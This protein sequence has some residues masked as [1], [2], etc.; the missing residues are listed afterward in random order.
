M[1]AGLP[2][3]EQANS[4]EDASEAPRSKFAATARRLLGVVGI[5][6]PFIAMLTLGL[7]S[8]TLNVIG[9]LLLGRATDLVLAGVIGRQNPGMDKSDVIDRLRQ[10]GQSA[11]AGM[12]QSTGF[13]PGRSS[14][15]AAVSTI[16]AIALGVYGL[17]GLCWILQGRQATRA[18]QRSAYRLRAEAES[19]LA[20]LPLSYFDSH[21]RGEVLSRITNDIDN[22]VQ[23]LQQSMSQLSN[24][25]LLIVGVLVMMFWL[26]PLL[27]VIAV[28]VVPS[29]MAVTALLGRRAQTR[30][31]EQWKATGQLNAYVEEL[32]DS[33][34]LVKAFDRSEASA[35]AFRDHNEVLFRSAFRA[36]LLSG[37]SQPMMNF[38]NNLGYVIVAVVGCLRVVSGTMSIGD[39]QAFI[40]YSRQ[41]SGPLTQVTSLAG[42]VQSG[43]ASAE[44]VFELMDAAEEVPDTGRRLRQGTSQGLVA[45]ESVSFGY[46]PDEPLIEDLSLT[47]EPG[48]TVAIV[49]PTGAG[50]TTLINLLLRF[51][52]VTGGRITLDGVDIRS[53]SR[54][55]LRSEIGVVLQDAWLF[56][57]S[58][59]DNIAYGREGAT[60][61]QIEAAARSAH[62]DHL[63][64]TLPNGYDT[65]LDNDSTGVS[66]GER[67]LITIA[68]AFLSDPAIL[69][70]DEATSSVDTRTELLVR[71]AMA[72]LSRGR[73]S[74]VIAHRLSTV[75]DADTIVVMENGA[76]VEQGTHTD[77]LAADG[78]Y[79]V[80]YRAQ[81]AMPTV[82]LN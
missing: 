27:A 40:Q 47:V 81:F 79:S 1:R 52:D 41:L 14:D 46:E 5:Q 13:T 76:I 22:V 49:G 3:K 37:A 48:K 9:P 35:T 33:H 28:V 11:L 39:V 65:V 19:K 10:Q 44:R 4:V 25:L 12:L 62:A 60:R 16:L 43:I 42:V 80:L 26:S 20:R 71:R 23:M 53:L 58:I 2:Q 66:A 72:Q 21:K 29:A 82:E 70:L 75:R 74:F 31:A 55:A 15:L 59:A 63:I 54:N 45:F 36:Q 67:Q 32:Y 78:A 68:R 34:A 17:S 38:I 69:V 77:L 24:S 57:G 8:I 30:F 73:T 6:R 64:R 18:I 51:Y 7:A 56:T 50:K 61:E